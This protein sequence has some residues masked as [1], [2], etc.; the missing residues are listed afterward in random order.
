MELIEREREILRILERISGTNFILVGGYA[1]SSLAM[2]RF[3]VDCDLVVSK[4]LARI[5]NILKE[6]GYAPQYKKEGFDALYGGRFENY[7]KKINSTSVFV[8]LLINSLVS[9]GTNA[10]WSFEYIKKHSIASKIGAPPVTCAV[11]EK[12]L[13][14]AMKIHSGRKADI[15]DIIML[16]SGCDL[17]K[18]V[19]HIKRG[20]EKLLLDKIDSILNSL[21]DEKM[22][23]SLKGV[24]RL[25]R[26]VERDIRNSKKFMESI[27]KEILPQR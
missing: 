6:E 14:V 4:D 20:D 25:E 5:K 19:K 7:A 23:D 11:P 26:D 27:R 13:L 8:D 17:E 3:S 12:E 18:V 21:G 15:R 9:R 16:A 1:V 24:F 10:S 2:H 22:I